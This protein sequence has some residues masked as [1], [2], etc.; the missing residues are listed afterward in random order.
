MHI[1][2]VKI[3]NLPHLCQAMFSGIYTH[4]RILYQ[5]LLNL[6]QSTHLVIHACRYAVGIGYI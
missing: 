2:F 5:L 4:L 6:V 1:L 3:W